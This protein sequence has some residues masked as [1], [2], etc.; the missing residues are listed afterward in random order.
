MIAEI[1]PGD[2]AHLQVWRD[3]K[4][5]MV[6][7]RVAELKETS[8]TASAGGGGGGGAAQG[9]SAVARSVGLAVRTLTSAEK[10][11]LKTRG[12]VVITDVS[13]PAADA[14]LQPGDVILSIN[15]TPITDIGQ[16]Q[17]AIRA[18]REW[19]LLVQRDANGSS[20][21]LIVTISLQ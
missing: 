2:V 21:Q 11:Q 15:R 1:Q 8:Q 14:M 18:G 7:V 6:D 20:Q 16:F 4:T 13:G 5:I 17:K 12:A 3:R 19:T 9:G 10:T